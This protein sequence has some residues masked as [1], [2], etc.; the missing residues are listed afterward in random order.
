MDLDLTGRTALVSGSTAG[1]GLAIVKGLARQGATVWLNGRTQARVDAALADVRKAVGGAK[2]SGIA[3]DAATSEG[4]R[5]IAAALPEVDVL[6]NNLGI[7]ERAVFE[8]ISDADWQRFFDVNVMSGVR[9][10]RH[11]LPAMRR[12]NWGRIVFISSESATHIP[13]DMVHYGMSKTAQVSIARGVAETLVG[14]GVTVNSVLP[15]P[16]RAETMEKRLAAARAEGKSEA[17]FEREFFEIRRPTSLLRRFTTT[18]EVA[19]MVCYVCSPAASGTTGA[20][21]RVE[22]GV[23]RAIF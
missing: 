8:E 14:T 22:G 16:T 11:Y 5:A 21:L 10:T 15:G 4:C 23:V 18:D 3:A 1:I 7:Y 19:N 6:V 12:R 13:P 20:A 2:V 9:L 17:E